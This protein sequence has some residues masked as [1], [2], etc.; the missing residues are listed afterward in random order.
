[1]LTQTDAYVR[2]GVPYVK[3]CGVLDFDIRKIFDCG[4]CFRFEPVE[5]T[6]HE[7]EFSGIAYGRFIS[8]AQDRNDIYI[9]NCT[10]D[11]LEKIWKRYLALDEDY[12]KIKKLVLISPILKICFYL[13]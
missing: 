2:E 5:D 6:E 4:Q 11:E 3:I 12:E 13:Q 7:A 9:H 10:A 8:V 1:M